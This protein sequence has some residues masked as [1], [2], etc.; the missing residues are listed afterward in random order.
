MTIDNNYKSQSTRGIH[1]AKKVGDE[2]QR[3]NKYSN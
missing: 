3:I 2:T 1:T